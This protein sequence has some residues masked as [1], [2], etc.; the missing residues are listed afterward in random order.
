MCASNLLS[1]H[2]FPHSVCREI[3][4]SPVELTKAIF[5]NF[6][7]TLAINTCKLSYKAPCPDVPQLFRQLLKTQKRGEPVTSH[8]NSQL[9]RLR[10][11]YPISYE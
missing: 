4:S 7:S 2:N 11:Y 5:C 8:F 1:H 9:L 3:S 10:K 6:K